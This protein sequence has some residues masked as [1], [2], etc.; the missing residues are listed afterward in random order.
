[1][2]YTIECSIK[3]YTFEHTITLEQSEVQKLFQ[4]NET[5]AQNDREF[6]FRNVDS[7]SSRQFILVK[8]SNRGSHIAM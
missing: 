7:I 3:F 4:V 1:M 2:L 5:W 8:R 6:D